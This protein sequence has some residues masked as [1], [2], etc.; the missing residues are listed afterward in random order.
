MPLQVPPYVK[1]WK[2]FLI[3]YLFLLIG[4]T[5]VRWFI[6]GQNPDGEY[7]K[8]VTVNKVADGK[9]LENTTS[10]TYLDIYKGNSKNPPVIVLISGSEVNKQNLIDL[11]ASLAD[12]ARVIAPFYIDKKVPD[13]SAKAQAQYIWQLLQHENITDVHIISHGFGGAAAIK[14]ISQ[15]PKN[16]NSLVLLSST[17]VQEL[18]LLGSYQL[19]QAVYAIQLATIWTIQNFIPHFGALDQLNIDTYYAKSLFETDHRTIRTILSTFQKPAFIIHGRD[20]TFVPAGN[21]FEHQRIIPQSQLKLYDGGYN[22]IQTSL[23]SLANDISHFIASVEAGEAQIKK[24][25]AV[26]KIVQS[27]LPFDGAKGGKLR[28][29]ALAVIIILIILSTLISE[30]LTCIGAGLMVARGIIGFWPA[31]FGCLAG[32]FF[33]DILIYLMGRSLGRSAIKKRPVKW[34]LNESDIDRT[35]QWFEVK[36]P[37]IIIASRFI[38]GSRFPTY[39]TAG[40]LGAS[41]L[42][43]I[44]YFGVASIIWTPLLVGLAVLIGQ[45]LIGY[46]T[47][48]QDYAIWIVIATLLGLT[49]IFHVAIPLFTYK[50]RRLWYGKI[51]RITN[52]E[53]WPP[54]V[55]YFPVLLSIIWRWKTY[56]PSVFAAANPGIDL[57]G[58]I[59]ESKRAILD[60]IGS[61]DQVAVYRFLPNLYSYNRKL[62]EVNEFVRDKSLNYPVVLKPD[63]GERGRGVHIIKSEEQLKKTLSKI[64]G[65]YLVQEYAH[66]EEFGI[67]YYRFPDK[68]TGDIFSITEKRLL[69]LTA[70]GKCTI[71][72]LILEHPRAVCLA[73]QHFKV[74]S[75]KLYTVPE[76]GKKI[77]LVEL[78]T[79]ARGAIFYDG[80]EYITEELLAQIEKIAQSIDGFYFGRFDIKV[81]SVKDLKQGKNIKIVELNGVSSEAAHIYQPGYSVFN[82]WKILGRQWHLAYQIGQKNVDHGYSCPSVK[83]LLQTIFKHLKK[84]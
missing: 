60:K 8:S 26:L 65:D 10:L 20:D 49:F 72:K 57:G 51:K 54:Y 63:V 17:G 16:V 83:Q 47:I 73:E 31:V 15:K 35:Y 7:E 78:G 81:P 11:S 80:R 50:G 70:D 24:D 56:R 75:N 68:K 58:F 42:M 38:P 39:F 29:S 2:A 48:Y 62:Q 66:G 4:S 84:K 30:D 46:F 19:N 22:I 53:F 5:A 74:H 43:F 45:E 14:F 18:E 44:L 69:N 79:H 32:I 40:A 37:A 82:A 76:K 21:A 33:G 52:W 77:K 12:S 28:G 6:P 71:E 34:F 23:P 61:K 27:K 64:H 13:Y 67:F 25:V 1:G 9:L 59:G 3:I 36:G 41:F 55:L